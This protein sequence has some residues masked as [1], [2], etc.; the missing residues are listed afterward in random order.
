M[1]IADY[2][3]LLRYGGAI[4]LAFAAGLLPNQTAPTTLPQRLAPIFTTIL[5]K[6]EIFTSRLSSIGIQTNAIPRHAQLEAAIRRQEAASAEQWNVYMADKEM[7]LLME[8]ELEG[9]RLQA[10]KAWVDGLFPPTLSYRGIPAD[11]ELDEQVGEAFVEVKT[12]GEGD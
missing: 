2:L 1:Q 12:E 7:I 4:I 8:E 10:V 6:Q 3:F 9:E 11:S 5:Q